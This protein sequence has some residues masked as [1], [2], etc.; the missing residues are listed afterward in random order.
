MVIFPNCKINLGLRILRK[1]TDGYHDLET[2]F[3]PVAIYDVLELLPAATPTPSFSLS[4]L[5]VDGNPDSNLCRKA[6]DLL[7]HQFPEMP[8]VDIWLHKVIPLGAG[9]GGGSADG[10]FMLRALNEKFRLGL[11]PTQLIQYALQLGSDCPF[12]IYNQ[13]CLAR[14]RGEQLTPLLPDLNGYTISIVN[15]GI[16]ISTAW[17]FQQI[18]PNPAPPGSLEAI[19][20]MPP[21]SWRALLVNDFE[22]P[23]CQHFPEIGHI[24]TQ[25]YSQ[26]AVYAALSGSGS[27]VFGIFREPA[28]VAPLFPAHYFVREGL[29][30]GIA[31]PAKNQ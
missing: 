2:V 18:V 25:L 26:G 3:L 7:H 22:G 8:A 30:A 20:E 16:S 21:E 19:M 17:A 23:V 24:I 14:G 27:T 4:G 29:P 12:F 28:T 13:P 9:L 10:A 5:P 31:I 11:T 15:P 1:R 6:W